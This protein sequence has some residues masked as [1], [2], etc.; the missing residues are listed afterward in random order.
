MIHAFVIVLV[1]G[2]EVGI[3]VVAQGVSG[4][5]AIVGKEELVAVELISYC[6][7]TILSIARLAFPVLHWKMPL[8]H[9]KTV[10]SSLFIDVKW[11]CVHRPLPSAM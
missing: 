3:I 1:G 10:F 8:I 2:A 6:E 7:E 11:F 9:L 5:S 4:I